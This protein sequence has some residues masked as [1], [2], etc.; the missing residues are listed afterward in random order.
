M[1]FAYSFGTDSSYWDGSK[2]AIFFFI[3][4]YF[5]LISELISK[6]R[7]KSTLEDLKFHLIM[8]TLISSIFILNSIIDLNT[9]PY[10]QPSYVLSYKNS[11][12]IGNSNLFYL[13]KWQII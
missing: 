1:P 8:S 2:P 11:V 7:K 5:L 13:M 3:S 4:C 6:V 10:R 12:K 9:D